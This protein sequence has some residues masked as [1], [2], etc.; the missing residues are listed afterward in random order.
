[1]SEKY[2]LAS[3]LPEP[4]AAYIQAK[5]EM[6]YAADKAEGYTPEAN[7]I[8]NKTGIMAS[9]NWVKIGTEQAPDLYGVQ[10]A[11]GWAIEFLRSQEDANNYDPGWGWDTCYGVPF[12]S[13]IFRNRVGG[14][15]S[16][17]IAGWVFF[18]RYDIVR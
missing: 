3:N 7:M 10:A 9:N 5:Y 16:E 6:V 18:G 12:F 1:M 2:Y 14:L 15:A 13:N 17:G 11:I 8:A 4:N